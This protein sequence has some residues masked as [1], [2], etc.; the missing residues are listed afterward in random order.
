[1]SSVFRPA[2][3]LRPHLE[4]NFPRLATARWSAKSPYDDSYQCIAWAAGDVSRKWWP[5]DNPPICFW[6][7]GIPFDDRVECFVQAFKTLGYVP[8]EDDSFEPG[9]QK[10]A[11]YATD[12]MIV[13]HMARQHFLGR[14]WLSKLG[15]L[16]DIF[17][18]DLASLEGDPSPTAYEYG[19]VVQILKRSWWSAANHGLFQSFSAALKFWF[20]RVTH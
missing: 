3:I 8:C 4:T 14:G 19:R 10:V 16:E 11:I 6:P 17:H 5:V 9:Y 2:H 13:R 12:T 1:M 15:N 7:D 18:K 20:M